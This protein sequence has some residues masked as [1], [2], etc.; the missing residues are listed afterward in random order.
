ME[1][2]CLAAGGWLDGELQNSRSLQ[3]P[4]VHRSHIPPNQ[5]HCTLCSIAATLYGSLALSSSSQPLLPYTVQRLVTRLVLCHWWSVSSLLVCVRMS[6]FELVKN[7]PAWQL[8]STTPQQVHA[9]VRQQTTQQA[10]HAG[11]P[12]CCGADVALLSLCCVSAPS[13]GVL[14]SLLHPSDVLSL[15][16]SER[17]QRASASPPVAARSGGRL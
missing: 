16:H 13:A 5:P 1:T 3:Q 6:S 14:R 15:Q 4:P 2:S 8:S 7:A 9:E 10:A 12:R 17:Q 11:P